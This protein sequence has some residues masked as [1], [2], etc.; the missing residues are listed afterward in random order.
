MS[1]LWA[2]VLLL[3]TGALWGSGFVAQSMAMA[4]IGPLLFVGLRFVAAA[5][6][7]LPLAMWE[8]RNAKRPLHRRNWM[9]FIWIGVTLFAGSAAQQIGLVVTSVSNSGF[10]TSLY[11]IMVPLLSVL[12][13]RQFPHWIVWPAAM[14]ALGGVY[15]LSGGWA[16]SLNAG[17]WFTVLSAV[18]WAIQIVLIAKYAVESERPLAMAFIQFALTG[19]LGIVT[20]LFA[21]KIDVAGIPAAVPL[22]LYAGLLEGALAFTLQI[23]AQRYTTS[24]NAA[25]M[26]ASE[27]PFAA[28]FGALILGERLSPIALGGGALIVAAMLAVEIVPQLGRRTLAP[29]AQQ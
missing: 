3:L 12:V 13:F 6:A 11:I 22:I 16:G 27:A 23:V 8:A 20:A 17:D 21:E 29:A 24:S 10:L 1:R 26:L 2:N 25:I 4:S 14:A 9:P 19:F 28:L 7:L 5:L 15:L 18:F